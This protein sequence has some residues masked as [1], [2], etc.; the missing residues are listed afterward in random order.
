VSGSQVQT[1]NRCRIAHLSEA[2]IQ[3]DCHGETADLQGTPSVRQGTLSLN[4]VSC[5]VLPSR[6]KAETHQGRV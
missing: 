5:E 4:F 1:R 6:R 2:V 3:P